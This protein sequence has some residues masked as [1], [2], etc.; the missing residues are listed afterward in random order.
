MRYWHHGPHGGM[1]WLLPGLTFLVVVL[2]LAVLAAVLWRVSARRSAGGA[3]APRWGSP[4]GPVRHGEAERLLAERLA[5]G[6]VE[7]EEYRRRLA[8][9]RGEP[10]GDGPGPGAPPGAPGK[11]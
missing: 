10:A 1:P 3:P 2:L 4:P 6:E 7:V 9:L 11:N 8:A 5:R